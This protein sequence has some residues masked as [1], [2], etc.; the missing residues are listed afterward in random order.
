MNGSNSLA[1]TDGQPNRLCSDC[2]K[3]LAWDLN[4]DNKKRLLE[5]RE[6][7]LKHKLQVDYQLANADVASAN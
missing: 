3:K 1:E 2:L 6:Y 5:L 4:F 7:F